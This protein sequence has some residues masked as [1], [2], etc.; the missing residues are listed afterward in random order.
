MQKEKTA[1]AKDSNIVRD[2][3][4]DTVFDGINQED[5]SFKVV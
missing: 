4:F 5:N 2:T 3:T 1:L